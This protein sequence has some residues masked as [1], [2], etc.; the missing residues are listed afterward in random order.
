MNTWTPA[1]IAELKEDAEFSADFLSSEPEEAF[2]DLNS[3][4]QFVENWENF[5]LNACYFNEHKKSWFIELENKII[6]ISNL[7]K[8][9]FSVYESAKS[10]LISLNLYTPLFYGYKTLTSHFYDRDGEAE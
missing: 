8:K 2:K 9:T 10:F 7:Y 1:S 5:L 6:N 4:S 3:I